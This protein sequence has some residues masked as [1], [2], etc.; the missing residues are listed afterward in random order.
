M[1][2]KITLGTKSVS[3]LGSRQDS[4]AKLKNG[5]FSDLVAASSPSQLVLARLLSAHPSLRD[6]AQN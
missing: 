3:D 5:P 1:D 6:L 2:E 4:G